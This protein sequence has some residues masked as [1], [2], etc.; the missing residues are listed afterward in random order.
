[1][2]P[3]GTNLTA[4]IGAWTAL[5]RDG[6]PDDLGALLDDE[7]VWQGLLPHL[8]CGSRTEVMR[9]LGR[10]GQRPLRLTRIEAQEFGDRVVVSVESPDLPENE[11]I[12][13][14][15][16][17]SLVFTFESGKVVRMQSLASRDAAFRMASA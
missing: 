8:V 15:A 5:L 17:R 4:V 12:A 10:F 16:P 14:G 9:L 1:M 13:G 2:A 11:G 6:R 7:V 3:P